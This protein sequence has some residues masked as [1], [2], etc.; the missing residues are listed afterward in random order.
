MTELGGMRALVTGASS[1]IGA[2]I[3]RDLARRGA[4]LVVTARRQDALAEVAAAC[5]G[6]QVVVADLGAPDGA[7]RVWAEATA[8]GKIDILIN[9]AGFGYL[10]VFADSPWARDREMLQL[11]ITSLVELTRRF[12]DAKPARGFILNIAS[13]GAYTSLP[14][15]ALYAAT[16]AFVRNFTEALHDELAGS[17]VSATSV[18]PGGVHTAFHAV[19][20]AG[21][22]GA[23]ARASMKSADY[24]ASYSVRAMLAR[25]RNVIPGF[26]NQLSCWGLGLIPRSLGSWIGR[27][28]M[29]RPKQLEAKTS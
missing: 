29:G 9:N 4:S 18:C 12:L 23:I 24:V 20:G 26:L 6:A 10:R 7:E 17:E 16:K 28:I 5:N 19:A 3:A 21:N 25:K 11:N 22:Y 15:M 13:I 14:N 27:R 1:G 8:T 2:A